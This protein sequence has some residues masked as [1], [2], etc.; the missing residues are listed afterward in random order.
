[1]KVIIQIVLENNEQDG[2]EPIIEK[3]FSFQRNDEG[4]KIALQSLGLSLEEAKSLLAGVHKKL[5]GEQVASYLSPKSNCPHCHQAYQ[6]KGRH[7]ISFSTLFGK[8]KLDS[9]RFYRCECQS[10]MKEPTKKNQKRSSF[11]PL[12]EL[13]LARTAPEFTYLQT[14]WAALMS[15]GLTSQFLAEV[16]P[17]D[18]PISPSVLSKRKSEANRFAFR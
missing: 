12:A 5:V 16:L 6:H 8:L 7:K 1:M 13:L 2:Q 10:E 4:D 15:Y 3:I 11:S 18:K 14:K 17:L 9:P